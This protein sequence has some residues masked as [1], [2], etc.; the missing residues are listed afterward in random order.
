MQS[1]FALDHKK[2]KQK[3]GKDFEG[4]RGFGSRVRLLLYVFPLSAEIPVLSKRSS[5]IH[6]FSLPTIPYYRNIF[7]GYTLG[8]VSVS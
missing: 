8:A 2:L 5:N 1:A 7:Q 4:I 3:L 6:L